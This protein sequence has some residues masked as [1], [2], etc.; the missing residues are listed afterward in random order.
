MISTPAAA[1]AG[2]SRGKE[3]NGGVG[4]GRAITAMSDNNDGY[5]DNG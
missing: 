2:D 5:D 3:S 4:G 1:A